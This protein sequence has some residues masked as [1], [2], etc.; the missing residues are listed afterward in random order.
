[1]LV[2]LDYGVIIYIMKKREG[3]FVSAR[4]IAE[5]MPFLFEFWR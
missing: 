4:E 5:A 2:F 1:M 3:M